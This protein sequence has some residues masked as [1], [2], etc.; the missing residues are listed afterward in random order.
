MKLDDLKSVKINQLNCII[1]EKKQGIKTE[2]DQLMERI[3]LLQKQMDDYTILQSKI[4]EILKIVNM[5]M[6][7]I[8]LLEFVSENNAVTE[9]LT[10]KMENLTLQEVVGDVDVETWINSKLEIIK[11][12]FNNSNLLRCY[13]NQIEIKNI[14]IYDATLKAM[15]LRQKRSDV[16]KVAMDYLVSNSVVGNSFSIND[17]IQDF[18]N[19]RAIKKEI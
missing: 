13:Q 12:D 5:P 17:L 7:T 9:L 15:Y 14:K 10:L 18:R 4:D 3:K 8:S 6:K 16:Y 1:S 2:Y 19:Y 11:K